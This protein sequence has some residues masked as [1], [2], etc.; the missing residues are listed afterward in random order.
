MSR[1]YRRKLL[2]H[3]VLD[4]KQEGH[5]RGG[6]PAQPR[7]A[8]AAVRRAAG[9][10]LRSRARRPRAQPGPHRR[11]ARPV[12]PDDVAADQRAAGEDR[13]PR[14]AAPP[15]DARRPLRRDRPGSG[16]ARRRPGP[17]RRHRGHRRQPRP[18]DAGDDPHRPRRPRRAS[19]RTC[20]AAPDPPRSCCTPLPCSRSST[21][22]SPSCCGCTARAA[23]TRRS[24]TC[25]GTWPPTSFRSPDA[26]SSRPGPSRGA[27][28]DCPA[29][30]RG[31]GR[32]CRAGSG[33]R[34][35]R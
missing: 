5:G 4:S 35:G 12:P 14:R 32:R 25:A 7:A 3:A 24:S 18:H 26:R 17:A 34:G 8:G 9:R 30:R 19:S 15:P 22:G 29:G 21:R 6:H 1:V 10:A 11:G 13:Q 27:A 33:S 23:P 16:P 2:C 28:G 31:C 20:C